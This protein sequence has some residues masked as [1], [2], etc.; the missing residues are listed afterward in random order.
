MGAQAGMQMVYSVLKARMLYDDSGGI[1]LC[2]RGLYGLHT[3]LELH[4][5]QESSIH[6]KEEE[7]AFSP[8]TRSFGFA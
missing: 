4:G 8:R 5:R 6:G 2:E 7:K 3:Y 1:C